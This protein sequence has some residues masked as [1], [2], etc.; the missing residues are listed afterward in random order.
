LCAAPGSW[1]QVL[2]KKLYESSDKKDE[3][4]IIAVGKSL[5]LHTYYI[6]ELI[7][8]YNHID[9]QPMSPLN[10]VTQLQ[11]DITK[12]ETAEAIISHFGDKKAQLVISD[13]KLVNI[14]S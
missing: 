4:K 10:G 9:L 3:V 6:Q 5:N 12:L 7:M 13:G 11:G 1:S 14:K 2:S 8:T